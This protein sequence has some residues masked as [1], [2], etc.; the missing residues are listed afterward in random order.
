MGAILSCRRNRKNRHDILKLN[1][2]CCEEIF[3]YLSIK[4]L[5]SF[6]Q[7]CKRMNRIAGIHFQ[8]NYPDAH[9]IGRP[10]GI[11]YDRH[12]KSTMITRNDP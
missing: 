3:E 5:Y 6:G 1:D 7:T 10:K 9:I 8:R 4:D 2:D 11:Y 12:N